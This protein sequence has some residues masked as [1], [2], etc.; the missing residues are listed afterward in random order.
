MSDPVS[1]KPSLGANLSSRRRQ[2]KLSQG[3][4][5]EV[6]LVEPGKDFPLLIQPAKTVEGLSLAGWSTGSRERIGEM[7][8]AHGA[9]LFRGFLLEGIEGFQDF[10][11]ALFDNLLDYSYRS[12]PR[13][14]VSDKIY[15]STEYPANQSIPM[16]NEMSYTRQWPLKIAFHCM[17]AA[18]RG[19]ATPIADSRRVRDRIEPAIREKFA[20]KGVLY[21]RNY[22]KHL[23]LS[24]EEVFQTHDRG[25]VEKICRELDLDYEWL[26]GGRLRTRQICQALA[27]HPETG[28]EVWFNQAHLFHVSSLRAEVREA[29]LQ[30]S[31]EEDLP[32]NTYY[33]DG[34]AIAPE[35]LARIR[36][37]YRQEEVRFAWQPGDVLL[38]DNMLIAH[39]REPFEGPRK[40]VVGMAEPVAGR[41]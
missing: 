13:S 37:A 29:L 4:L 11:R 16:H 28:E 17:I 14:L 1:G 5:V 26:E 20:D 23:D 12:T 41:S 39:G 35:T 21:V 31:R 36:E 40:V 27:V 30:S 15:T 25:E 22:G 7:L 33:G 19:G 6:G 9:I 38:L 8:R 10:L 24:W 18:A 32:R 2:V 3:E 34:S